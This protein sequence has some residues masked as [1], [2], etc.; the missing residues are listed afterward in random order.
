[1]T[2]VAGRSLGAA[3]DV[4]VGN[5][6]GPD[7]GPDLDEDDVFFAAGAALSARC[8]AR[9]MMLTSLS[10][11]TGASKRD[12]E[13]FPDRIVVPAGH[14]RRGNRPCCREFDGPRHAEADAPR[15]TRPGAAWTMVSS[16][17]SVLDTLPSV[18]SGPRAMSA[19][20]SRR[21]SR[22]RPLRVGDGNVDAGRPEIGDQ[23]VA[24][25]RGE[26]Q[27]AWRP[28][29]RA[30]PG[31]ALGHEPAVDQL[32]DA[33]GDDRPRQAGTDDELGARPR[34]AEPDLVEDRDQRVERL[35]GERAA[36]RSTLCVR[37]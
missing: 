20:S 14:D 24:G 4:A 22:T 6:A 23:H 13:P 27:L 5:D 15:E 1:M 17:K 32:A 29:A 31:L 8:A 26:G 36:F 16:S 10:T 9:A 35:L 34:P 11:Q 21:W 28:A 37:P 2:D 3:L 33:L 19:G 30:R 18:K 25:V 12:R 7:P